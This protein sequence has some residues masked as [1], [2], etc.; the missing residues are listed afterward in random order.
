MSIS[1]TY[2]RI[3]ATSLLSLALAAQ[4]WAQK[5]SGEI[6]SFNRSLGLEGMGTDLASV[7]HEIEHGNP[8]NTPETSKSQNPKK[9]PLQKRGPIQPAESFSNLGFHANPAV[10]NTV[11][12]YYISRMN[13]AALVKCLAELG[14]QE[15]RQ[16]RQ[17]NNQAAILQ[18]QNLLTPFPLSLG[19]DLRQY[20]LTDQGF[21]R[22]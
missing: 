9:A 2:S 17:S 13:A 11:P 21:I 19:I 16:A 6:E 5:N 3:T 4:V 10:T 22:G 7:E 12:A 20:R 18:A 15:V 1:K 8:A 14:V